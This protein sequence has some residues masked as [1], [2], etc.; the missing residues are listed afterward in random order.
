MQTVGELV[1]SVLPGGTT[2]LRAETT[3][4]Y[5]ACPIFP[6]DLFAVAGKLAELSGAYHHIFPGSATES[7]GAA[8]KRLIRISA[9]DVR[10]AEVQARKWRKK[11][12][13]LAPPAVE[14]EWAHLMTCQNE[15][16]FQKRGA[17]EAPPKWWKSVIRLLMVADQASAGIG[18]TLPLTASV[19]SA[20]ESWVDFLASYLAPPAALTPSS[21]DLPDSRYRGNYSFSSADRNVLC[22][23]PKVRTSGVGCSL[24]SLTHNLS[25]LPPQ[26]VARIWW[27]SQPDP[28]GDNRRPLNI[29]LI[30]YPYKI[31]AKCFKQ[32]GEN[33]D[34]GWGWFEL[35]QRWLNKTIDRDTLKR[36]FARFVIDLVEAAAKDVGEVHGAIL[37]EL[38]LDFDL[39]KYVAREL[40]ASSVGSHIEFF[41]GGTS[42]NATRAGNFACAITYARFR[43]A[44]GQIQIVPFLDDRQKHHR[45]RLD[46]YQITRYGLTSALD[47]DLLW[48]EDLPILSRSISIQQLRGDSVYTSMI[49]EDLARVDPCQEALRSIGPNIMFALLMDGPQ[50]RSR[51]PARYATILAEDP[52]CSV[53]TLTSMGLIERA[54]ESGGDPASRVI[55]LWKDLDVDR[56]EIHLDRDALAVCI[57][58]NSRDQEEFTLDGRSDG[59]AAAV[60]TL[61]SLMQ[62]SRKSLPGVPA[63]VDQCP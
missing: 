4:T 2:T 7:E 5:D 51:W 15:H 53:L 40:A 29:V 30:P 20:E 60:W 13:P 1:R 54:N 32:A 27:I 23:L 14:R 45:W 52:G 47:P 11:L 19:D 48:W 17:N 3:P 44:V 10:W 33:P 24:R 58:L 61:G 36:E 8:S 43:D 39:F 46:R 57:T 22:V 21:T 49:C 25:L 50:L 35:E 41:V 18:F 55:A 9:G 62:I 28:P 42:G 34:L 31:S 38:A 56:R 12:N 37:P 6:P 16:L 59:S 63:W 26:G